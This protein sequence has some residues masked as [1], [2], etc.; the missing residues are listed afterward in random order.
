[1]K[2]IVNVI[3]VFLFL[4]LLIGGTTVASEEVA[5]DL[6]EKNQIYE[7]RYYEPMLVAEVEYTGDNGGFGA[8][9]NYISG[10]NIYSSKKNSSSSIKI[11]M[12]A[13]VTRLKQN[14]KNVMQ[15]FLPKRFTAETV[16]VPVNPNVKIKSIDGGYFAAITY[17]GSASENNFLKHVKILSQRLLSDKIIFFEPAIRATYNG[18]F[19]PPFM[20]RNEVIYKIQWEK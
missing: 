20:R 16:P 17:S 2:K 4:F 7:I 19:T 12:T 10:A 18:P 8:L 13:P 15:F 5:F 6:V 3:Y 9:F 11:E 14:N 1:M